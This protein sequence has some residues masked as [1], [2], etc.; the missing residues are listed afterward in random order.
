MNVDT[1]ATKRQRTLAE[2]YRWVGMFQNGDVDRTLSL[3]PLNSHSARNRACTVVSSSKKKK[4]L[5][6]L[7]L[8]FLEIY[9]KNTENRNLFLY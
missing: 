8:D 4:D 7:S 1:L 3:S 9:S 2:K 6:P 5:N